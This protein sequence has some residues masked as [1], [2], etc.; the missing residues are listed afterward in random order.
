LQREAFELQV[1]EGLGQSVRLRIDELKLVARF[2]AQLGAGFRAD[3]NPVEACG[4]FERAVGFDRNRKTP[5]VQV[6]EQRLVH[7]QEW[8]AAGEHDKA[9]RGARAPLGRDG[10]SKVGGGRI[11]AAA[12]A[13][14]TDEVRVAEAALRSGSVGLA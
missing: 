9:L 12:R 1:D 2:D 14:G 13:V 8:F 5:Y 10:V 7:L 11:G 4:G 6:V 3:A